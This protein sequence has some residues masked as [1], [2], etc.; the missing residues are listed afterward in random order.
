LRAENQKL[1]Y[2]EGDFIIF[3]DQPQNRYIIETL[4]PQGVDSFFSWNFFDSILG[5]KEH[6][7]EYVFED[8]AAR[9]LKDDSEM[10]RRLE[11]E[12]KKNPA[13]LQNPKLQLDWVYRNSKYYEKTHM[14]YP[15][16]RLISPAKIQFK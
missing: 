1:K 15:V 11:E 12:K 3:T 14:R 16:G 4:E 2:Y 5:Q 6:Y 7:S 10:L 9:L 13:L 8:E